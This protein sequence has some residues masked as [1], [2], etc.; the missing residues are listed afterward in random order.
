MSLCQALQENRIFRGESLGSPHRANEWEIREG[1]K[2]RVGILTDLVSPGA[3]H[4]LLFN[5]RGNRPSGSW[6]TYCGEGHTLS[7]GFRSSGKRR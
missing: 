7:T 2:L 1:I 3:S 4:S 6:G 5:T